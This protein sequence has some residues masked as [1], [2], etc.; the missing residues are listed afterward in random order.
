[1]WARGGGIPPPR[2]PSLPH[3]EGGHRDRCAV[4]LPRRHLGLRRRPHRRRP[5]HRRHRRR[6]PRHRRAA[7]TLAAATITAATL[8][9]VASA[10]VTAAVAAAVAAALVIAALAAA[11]ANVGRQ[12]QAAFAACPARRRVAHRA[13]GGRSPGCSARA[14]HERRRCG[15]GPLGSGGPVHGQEVRRAQREQTRSRRRPVATPRCS[16]PPQAQQAR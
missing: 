11:L 4:L 3:R 1:M 9:A 10:T 13:V 12:P 15:T 7:A 16:M 14:R 6:H 5:H 8:A 2:T